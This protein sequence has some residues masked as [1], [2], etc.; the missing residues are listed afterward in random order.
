M[1]QKCTKCHIEKIQSKF[2]KDSRIAR[3]TAAACIK[4]K[5]AANRNRLNKPKYKKE[6]KLRIRI[7]YELCRV[8]KINAKLNKNCVDCG[9]KYSY[10]QLQFDHVR[11]EKKFTIGDGCRG[12]RIKLLEEI[13]KCDIV[14]VNCHSGRTMLQFNNSK[15]PRFN[16]KVLYVR[17][18]K[19]KN[20]TCVDCKNIFPYFK[21]QFD[22]LRDKKFN[23][24]AVATGKFSIK[25]IEEEIL[26]CEIVCGNCHADRTFY[27]YI[28]KEAVPLES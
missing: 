10:W 9:L 4:C 16:H 23:L 13:Q 20:N 12:G 5:Y 17:N 27:R 6:Q 25:E 24:S 3:G 8:L 22:H 15:S 2:P 19:I 21:L 14:C 11:G 26:K 1:I 18:F 28:D 7:N